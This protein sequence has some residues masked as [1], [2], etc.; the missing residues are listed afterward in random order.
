MAKGKK[1]AKKGGEQITTS[2]TVSLES[3]VEFTED[4]LK[5]LERDLKR[6][7]FTVLTPYT[8]AQAYGIRISTAKKIL[9]AAAER[10][11][12]VL[13]SGGRTP[14]YVKPGVGK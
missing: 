13:Y 6:N 3:K 11:I 7:T 9:R 4:I 14:V 8:L 2:K 12:L 10:G 1:A 5:K